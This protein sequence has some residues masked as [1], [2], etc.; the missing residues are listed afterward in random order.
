MEPEGQITCVECG[1][2]AHLITP[3]PEEGELEL[4]DVLVYR[5][6]DCLERWDIVYAEDDVDQPS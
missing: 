4:G 1:G 6:E 3:L 2:R 5:C